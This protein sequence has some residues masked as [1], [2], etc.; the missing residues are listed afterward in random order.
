VKGLFFWICLFFATSL[1]AFTPDTALKGKVKSVRS[2][3][4]LLRPIPAGEYDEPWLMNADF[5]SRGRTLTQWYFHMGQEV[6]RHEFRYE[7][8]QEGRERTTWLTYFMT[9]DLRP[10]AERLAGY[11][12]WYSLKAGDNPSTVETRFETV[13]NH[14]VKSLFRYYDEEGRLVRETDSLS[15]LDIGLV[16]DSQGRIIEKR[17]YEGEKTYWRERY[18]YDTRGRLLRVIQ[19]DLNRKLYQREEYLYEEN[20][21]VF[22]KYLLEY[23]VEEDMVDLSPLEYPWYETVKTYNSENNLIKLENYRW[24]GPRGMVLTEELTYAYNRQNQL[25]RVEEINKKQQWELTYDSENNWISL[26]FHDHLNRPGEPLE[27]VRTFEYYN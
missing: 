27:W 11:E 23:P 22:S 5:D 1:T 12:H 13:Q 16:Y 10:P 4:V 7:E 9:P 18:F 21:T 26:I 2:F 8:D 19:S 20:R 6:R 14:P 25:I 24:Y 15:D 17:G 3:K